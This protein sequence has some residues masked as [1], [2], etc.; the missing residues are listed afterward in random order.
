ML[1][2]FPPQLAQGLGQSSPAMTCR[3]WPTILVAV[4]ARDCEDRRCDA[5]GSKDGR[6]RRRA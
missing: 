3:M 1:Q 6:D 2:C 4:A 5:E